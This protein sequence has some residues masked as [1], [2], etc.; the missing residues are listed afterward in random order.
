MYTND[1]AQMLYK[2]PSHTGLICHFIHKCT[3]VLIYSSVFI[4]VF[5]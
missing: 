2:L 4:R 5:I 3:I 1:V